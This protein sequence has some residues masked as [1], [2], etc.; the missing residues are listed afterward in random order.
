M[1]RRKNTQDE[2]DQQNSKDIDVLQIH[3]V[4]EREED[5]EVENSILTREGSGEEETI[6]TPLRNDEGVQE[7]MVKR[8]EL[9]TAQQQD[10]DIGP[11]MEHLE[12]NTVQPKWSEIAS[13]SSVTKAYW[14]QW[15]SLRLKDGILYRL[16]V[17]PTDDHRVQLILPR[18]YREEVLRQIHDSPTSGHFAANKTL[19]RVRQRFYWVG[20]WRD[21]K[22]YCSRCNACASRK[23]PGRKQRAPLR[24]Y[25]VGAPMERIAI[26]VLGPLPVT[27]SGSKYL[28]V[29]IDYFTKWPEAFAIPNQEATTVAKVLVEEFFCRFGVP[30]EIHSDQRRNF[31]SCF[32]RNMQT[33]ED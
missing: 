16:W 27:E 12:S 31:E 17:S 22:M 20:C 6:V 26:D 3:L 24:L 10:P 5:T 19:C 29:A 4:R 14:A 7:I 30:L 1:E 33:T 15:N 23:G 32:S 18:K 13:Q 2:G 11:I 8:E 9:K 21:V 25:N 28:L